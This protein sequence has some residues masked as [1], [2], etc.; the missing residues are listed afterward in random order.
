MWQPNTCLSLA[1]LQLFMVAQGLVLPKQ[2][3]S[4]E[5]TRTLRR[6]SNRERWVGGSFAGFE[7]REEGGAHIYVHFIALGGGGC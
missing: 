3:A 6:S 7:G 5:N 2:S 1:L 4:S